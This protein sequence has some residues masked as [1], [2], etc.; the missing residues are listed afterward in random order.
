MP[1]YPDGL[2]EETGQDRVIERVC[3]HGIAGLLHEKPRALSEWPSKALGT[4]RQE[5]LGQVFWELRHKALLD[6]LLD[7]LE[8]RDVSSVLL[9]GTAN[10]YTLYDHPHCRRR[11]DSDLLI[12]Q[13]DLAVARDV[14]TTVGFA[15]LTAP[16]GRFGD[17]HFQEVWSKQTGDGLHHDID[18]HWMVTNSQVLDRVLSVDEVF[19]RAIECPTLRASARVSDPV[20]R[21]MHGC[22]NRKMHSRSGYFSIDRNYYETDRLIW[23]EDFRRLMLGFS[24]ELWDEFCNRSKRRDLAHICLEGVRF[25]RDMLDAPLPP[26]IEAE[27]EASPRQNWVTQYIDR[28]S[29]TGRLLE[30]LR[31]MTGIRRRVSLVL[32]RLF[33]SAQFMRDKYPQHHSWP[34]IGLYAMRIA[35]NGYRAAQRI[36]R[37]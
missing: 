36:L 14:M 17:Y 7:A 22:L 10:A 11:G 3:F 13:S 33:P 29:E 15:R 23:A 35:A 9:K 18:L 28:P 21:L 37:Q 26:E 31:A 20:T 2:R 6:G 30:D 12:R 25:S 4:V 5:A 27:L 16:P 34:V 24:A 19:N 32:A 8:E 1:D